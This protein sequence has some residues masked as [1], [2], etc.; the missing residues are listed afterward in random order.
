VVGSDVTGTPGSFI[1]VP[2]AGASEFYTIR[3]N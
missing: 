1:A 2:K 3:S